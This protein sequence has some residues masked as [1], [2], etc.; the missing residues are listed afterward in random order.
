MENQAVTS[1]QLAGIEF[2]VAYCCGVL[3]A[4]YLLTVKE[5]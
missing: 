2:P 1:E 3:T 4:Y 5:K